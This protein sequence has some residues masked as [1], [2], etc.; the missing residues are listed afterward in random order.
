MNDWEVNAISIT[1]ICIS[2]YMLASTARRNY[3]WRKE[4]K[5]RYNMYKR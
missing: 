4:S 2:I 1:S 3:K 5:R